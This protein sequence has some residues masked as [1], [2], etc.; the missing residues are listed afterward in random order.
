MRLPH[1]ALV[2]VLRG[3]EL[4]VVRR[5]PRCGGYWHLV[6]GGVE[7]GET[8]EQAARRELREETGLDAAVRAVGWAF[9]Y[10]LAEEPERLP[11]FAPGVESVHVDVFTV[12]APPA[13]EPE[14]HWEHDDHRWCGLAEAQALLR[15][16]ESREL[17][18]RLLG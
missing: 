18:A 14:L 5:S 2:A 4:L 16:P 3:R 1:E 15:W 9:D 7:A 13:W 10:P 17:A 6:S 12:A 8:A 11:Q